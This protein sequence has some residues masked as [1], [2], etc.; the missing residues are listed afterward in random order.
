MARGDW[1][2]DSTLKRAHIVIGVDADGQANPSVG[3]VGTVVMPSEREQRCDTEITLSDAERASLQAIADRVYNA[4][5]SAEGLA[6]FYVA[7]EPAPAETQ[8]SAA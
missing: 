5:L 1:H 6:G 8:G 7:P 2:P 4:Q 3:V